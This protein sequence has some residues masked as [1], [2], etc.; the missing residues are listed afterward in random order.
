MHTHHPLH[1]RINVFLPLTISLMFLTTVHAEN[2]NKKITS[3]LDNADMTMS[4]GRAHFITMIGEPT[5]KGS[6]IWLCWKYLCHSSL[7]SPPP[8]SMLAVESVSLTVTLKERE[9]WC[10]IWWS[11]KGLLMLTA[12]T[13]RW[14]MDNLVLIPQYHFPPTNHKEINLEYFFPPL[15]S[16]LSP[17]SPFSCSK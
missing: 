6:T 8:W 2:P 16:F 11:W 3:Y 5:S 9:G 7:G 13:N 10:V 14:L 15:L 12:T 17:P 4:F 1:Q